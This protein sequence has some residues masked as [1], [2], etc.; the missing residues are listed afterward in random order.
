MTANKM[1]VDKRILVACVLAV[2]AVCSSWAVGGTEWRV[3]NATLGFTYDPGTGLVANQRLVVQHRGP[4]S[5]YFVTIST[6]QSGTFANRELRDGSGNTLTYQLYQTTALQDVIK[7]LSASPNQA[8]VLTGS[9]PEYTGFLTEALDVSYVIYIPP[10]QTLSAGTYTDSLNLTLYSGAFGSGTQ[11]DT[12]TLSVEGPV[13]ATVSIVL[14]SPGDPWPTYTFQETADQTM[15]FGELATGESLGYD[16]LVESNASFFIAL[17]SANAGVMA[18]TDAGD[19]S[20]VPYSLTFDGGLVDLSSGG[21]VIVGNSPG[22]R[23]S[24]VVTINEYGAA[25]QGS[26]EDVVTITVTAN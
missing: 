21:D 2:G 6:G 16:L 26:Y 22:F 23:Y 18:H 5:D 14:V 12:G 17:A 8:E 19:A 20:I 1:I 11:E 7:D 15:D 25:S 9:A 3:D 4:E 13:T 24:I 10:G